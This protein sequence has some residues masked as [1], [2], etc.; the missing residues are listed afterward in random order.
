MITGRGK[1]ERTNGRKDQWA[2]GRKGERGNKWEGRSSTLSRGSDTNVVLPDCVLPACSCTAG[3]STARTCFHTQPN[4]TQ[5]N[6]T[7]PNPTYLPTITLR[8]S[9]ITTHHH[10]SSPIINHQLS[11]A[12]SHHPNIVQMPPLRTHTV[13]S[14]ISHRPI[15]SQKENEDTLVTRVRSRNLISGVFCVSVLHLYG[16][17]CFFVSFPII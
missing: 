15:G 2:E 5:P 8:P 6:P 4:P 13:L 9:P 12:I 7:Q 17:F 3:L 16:S 1:P 14:C 10:P 11:P